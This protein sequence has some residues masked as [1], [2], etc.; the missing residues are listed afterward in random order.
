M[1]FVRSAIKKTPFYLDFLAYSGVMLVLK[2]AGDQIKNSPMN[3]ALIWGARGHHPHSTYC[4]NFV[5]YVGEGVVNLYVKDFVFLLFSHPG[6]GS[7][8]Y[9]MM[10]VPRAILTSRQHTNHIL[11]TTK[12]LSFSRIQRGKHCISNDTHLLC[13]FLL[14]ASCV[15]LHLCPFT[16][17][18]LTTW[19]LFGVSTMRVYIFSPRLCLG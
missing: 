11:W 4:G 8:S 12:R 17:S 9:V 1:A 10:A 15:H 19:G 13:P 3:C 14:C 6:R 18:I 2:F 7:S 5:Q 16:A